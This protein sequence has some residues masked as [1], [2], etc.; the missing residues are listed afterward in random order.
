MSKNKKQKG[1]RLGNF[2]VCV[3]TG[4]LHNWIV[5]RAVSGFWTLRFRDDN[6]MYAN[7]L[8]LAREKK[9]HN[10]LEHY[11]TMNFVLSNSI[12]DMD[13]TKDFYEAYQRRVERIAAAEPEPTEEE[14]QEALAEM[15]F[16]NDIEKEYDK[17]KD[18]IEDGEGD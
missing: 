1:L 7:L 16:R 15:E 5:F 3:E 9:Y 8:S 11:L 6:N 17:V 18:E 10:F 2:I 13:F 12:P 4:S 14:E